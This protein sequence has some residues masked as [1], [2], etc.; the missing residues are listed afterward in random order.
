[1]T[2]PTNTHSTRPLTHQVFLTLCFVGLYISLLLKTMISHFEKPFAFGFILDFLGLS[3][4]LFL[5]L[6]VGLQVGS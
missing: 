1:M 2:Y 3:L 6:S 4:F 5:A